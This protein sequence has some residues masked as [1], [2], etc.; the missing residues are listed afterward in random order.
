MFEFFMQFLIFVIFLVMLAA[1]FAFGGKDKEGIN[2]KIISDLYDP[3]ALQLSGISHR[4]FISKKRG[5]ILVSTRNY[6]K[7]VEIPANQIEGVSDIFDVSVTNAENVAVTVYGYN[8]ETNH[9]DFSL[10]KCQK[11]EKS[12]LVHECATLNKVKASKSS[13]VEDYT[14]L[15]VSAIVDI[16]AEKAAKTKLIIAA[17]FLSVIGFIYFKTLYG[18]VKEE[19]LLAQSHAKKL[20]NQEYITRACKNIESAPF[21]ARQRI[22]EYLASRPDFS[23]EI[24][25]LIG[26][27]TFQVFGTIRGENAFGGKVINYYTVRLEGRVQNDNLVWF[28]FQP[29]IDKDRD[30]IYRLYMQ[31]PN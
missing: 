1:L 16:Y 11:S 8:I 3:D 24:A 23:D 6:E 5:S 19:R 9:P 12:D 25:R 22:R 17:C 30:L 21:Q 27:C 18:P 31:N 29:V 2:K 20:E 4:V 13:T 14:F 15:D 10:I 7:V 26:S 28:T